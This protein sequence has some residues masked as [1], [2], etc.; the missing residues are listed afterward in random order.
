MI[1]I[2][3]MRFIRYINLFQRITG[4]RCNHCFEYNNIIL[5]AV[6]R[7]FVMVAI[8]KNNQNLEKLSNIIGKR[9]KVV[10]IPNGR[11]DIENFVSIIT[12]PIRFRGIEIKD[13]EAIINAD[14]QNKASL[15]GR[16]KKRLFEMENILEQYFGVKKVMIK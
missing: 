13:D 6:P 10:A 15:I 14:S 4:L 5:F 11:E 3:D 1:K 16:G 9:I 8:G 2:L 12:K 7:K